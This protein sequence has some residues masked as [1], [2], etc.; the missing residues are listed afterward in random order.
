MNSKQKLRLASEGIREA[1][2]NTDVTAL[3]ELIAGDYRGFDPQ[4]QPQD[5]EMTLSAYRPGGVRLER[6][7]VEELDLRVVGEVGIVTGIGDIAGT[8]GPY[9]FAHHVRFLDLYVHRDGRW[10]LYLSQVTP[11]AE[12]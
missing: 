9:E 8:W 10:Q 2:F 11:L 6:Y 3:Q 12:P 7:D 1:M 4:G 5:R